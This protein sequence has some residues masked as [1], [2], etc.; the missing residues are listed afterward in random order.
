MIIVSIHAVCYAANLVMRY[1]RC[2]L[3][4]NYGVKQLLRKTDYIEF[5]IAVN[6]DDSDSLFIHVNPEIIN[7]AHFH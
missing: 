6:R 3:A 7:N 2:T 5:D 4:I 1:L